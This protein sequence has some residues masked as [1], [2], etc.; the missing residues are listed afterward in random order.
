VDDFLQLGDKDIETLC[1][2]A[3]LEVST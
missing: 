3:G 2:S 1:S